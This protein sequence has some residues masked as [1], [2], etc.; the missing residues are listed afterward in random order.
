MSEASTQT[1][2]S[3][4]AE[5]EKPKTHM[6]QGAKILVDIGP[7]L[8]FFG[9][10]NLL[11]R[12]VG[13]DSIY[14]ATGIFIVTAIVA[15]L[16]ALLREGRVPLMLAVSTLFITVFGG[17]TIYLKDPI[18]VFYKPT[19]INMLWASVIFGGLMFGVNIWKIVFQA[20]FD[21]PDH[22]WR[23]FAIR[24]GLFFVFLAVLNEVVWRWSAVLPGADPLAFYPAVTEQPDFWMGFKVW[25]VLPITFAFTMLNLPLLQKYMADDKA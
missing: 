9:S 23:I 4:K 18:F 11:K 13:D 25:G 10:Y 5:R 16:Y 3:A 19:I 1:G 6:G 8:V 7:A 17:L 22:V 14:W 12:Y 21:L 15:L 20:V 24:W 2:H